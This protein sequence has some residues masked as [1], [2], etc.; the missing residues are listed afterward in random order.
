[1]KEKLAKYWKE[2]LKGWEYIPG[3]W[4]GDSDNLPIFTG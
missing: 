3:K 2:G 4:I 1:M